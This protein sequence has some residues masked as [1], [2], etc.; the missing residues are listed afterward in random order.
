MKNKIKN[1]YKIEKISDLNNLNEWFKLNI[2][3]RKDK[4]EMTDLFEP[5]VV[6][7]LSLEKFKSKRQNRTFW[8]LINCFWESGCSSFNNYDDMVEFYYRVAGLI[9]IKTKS[10][11]KQETKQMI[12]KAI[13]ILPLTHEVKQ[14]VYKMLRG[15]YEKYL[16]W[17]KVKKD[18]ATLVISTLMYDMDESQVMDSKMGKKYEEILNG[19]RK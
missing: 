18:K 19:M 3:Q 4:F 10:T 6:E 2:I 5:F 9:T 7:F 16:S 11:L 14:K 1:Y 13:R 12:Y 15:E 17:S 8:S